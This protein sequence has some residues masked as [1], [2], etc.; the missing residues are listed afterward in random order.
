MMKDKNVVFMG[1]P[2]FS[3]PVLE[4][5]IKNVNV[6]MVN[7]IKYIFLNLLLFFLSLFFIILLQ[8]NNNTCIFR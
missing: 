2:D 6:I 3:V 4:M 8:N 1:T 7:I 5:L